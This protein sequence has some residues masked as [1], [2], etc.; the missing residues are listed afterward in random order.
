MSTFSEMKTGEKI[1][2]TQFSEQKDAHDII[3]FFENI[4]NIWE[5]VTCKS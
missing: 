5:R 1:E 2:I 4:S 3:D